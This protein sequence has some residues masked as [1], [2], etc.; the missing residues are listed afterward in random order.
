MAEELGRR[1]GTGAAEDLT[2]GNASKR[3]PATPNELQGRIL[4]LVRAAKRQPWTPVKEQKA[5]ATV[6]EELRR[7]IGT[8]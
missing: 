6:A 3:Q 8:L 5:V 2:L 1:I 7:R 4:G